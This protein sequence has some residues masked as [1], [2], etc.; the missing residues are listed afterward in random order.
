[1]RKDCWIINKLTNQVFYGSLNTEIIVSN[2]YPYL[3]VPEEFIG[4]DIK[5]CT[6]TNQIILNNTGCFKKE[7]EYQKKCFKEFEDDIS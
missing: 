5:W 4:K 7:V 2:D 3:E 6:Q 1:M